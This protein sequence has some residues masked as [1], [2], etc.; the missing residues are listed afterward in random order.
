MKRD[1]GTKN[2]TP[3]LVE[4]QFPSNSAR[5]AKKRVVVKTRKLGVSLH[6]STDA[7]KY[8]K[9]RLKRQ[10]KERWKGY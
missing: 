10:V 4:S 9:F 8:R 3:P 2:K 6:K 7:E 1:P 5:A